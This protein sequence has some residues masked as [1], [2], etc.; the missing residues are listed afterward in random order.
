MSRIS[1]E[2]EPALHRGVRVAAADKGVPV[3][4]FM[5]ET[6]EE[7]LRQE[8]NARET[9]GLFDIAGPAFQRDWDNGWDAACDKLG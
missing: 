7:R 9:D 3:R 1:F 4:Q 2:V 8:A 5:L 6:I